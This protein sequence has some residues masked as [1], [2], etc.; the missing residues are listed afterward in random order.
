MQNIVVAVL[1]FFSFYCILKHFCL[2]LTIAINWKE[3][4][5]VLCL[6]YHVTNVLNVSLQIFLND[7]RNCVCVCVFVCVCVCVCVFWVRKCNLKRNF[8]V[9]ECMWVW[10]IVNLFGKTE[11]VWLWA[12]AS[13]YICWRLCI[14]NSYFVFTCTTCRVI[15]CYTWVSF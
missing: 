11:G 3:I 10:E 8:C 5:W 15:L 12:C 9:I 13:R 7:E 2:P 1:L 6:V 14:T 4:T